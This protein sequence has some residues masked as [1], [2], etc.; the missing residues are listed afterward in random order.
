[1]SNMNET[2]ND[3]FDLKYLE[4]ISHLFNEFRGMDNYYGLNL[5]KKDYN[6]LLDFIKDKV[7]VYEFDEDELSDDEYIDEIIIKS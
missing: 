4:E 2:E 5:F 7:V 1:M 6:D 3:F